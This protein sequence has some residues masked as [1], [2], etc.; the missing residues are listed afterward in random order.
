[1]LGEPPGS[2]CVCWGGGRAGA[3]AGV[4]AA[5]LGGLGVRSLAA[6]ALAAFLGGWALIGSLVA[7]RFIRSGEPF[8]AETVSDGVESGGLPFQAA[9]RAAR[10]SLPDQ[11][12][13]HALGPL[14][15][16][17][18]EA[19]RGVQERLTAAIDLG[20]VQGLRDHTVDPAQR[21]RLVSETGAGRQRGCPRLRC[22]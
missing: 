19:E 12:A 14:A 20:A 16:F 13:G 21:A 10:D 8:L 3:P 1:V 15:E 11:I 6:I 9:L 18:R 2:K 17:G 7:Q 5:S 4:V 22:F